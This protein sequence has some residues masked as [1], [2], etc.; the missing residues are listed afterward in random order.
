MRDEDGGGGARCRR[1]E[2]AVHVQR[3][4]EWLAADTSQRQR[5]RK[6]CVTW[7]G[8]LHVPIF[9][10]RRLAQTLESRQR[11][12]Q[13]D[14]SFSMSHSDVEEGAATAS[15]AAH[16]EKAFVAFGCR[17]G[18]QLSTVYLNK[19]LPRNRLA[20]PPLPAAAQETLTQHQRR[21]TSY[22]QLDNHAS[23]SLTHSTN[24]HRS[25]KA[26][27]NCRVSSNRLPRHSFAR[28]HPP[29]SSFSRLSACSPC[30]SLIIVH[31]SRCHTALRHILTSVFQLR[32]SRSSRSLSVPTCK[33]DCD[34][35]H[36]THP[37]RS[38]PLPAGK[39]CLDTGTAE[40][41][42]LWIAVQSGSGVT[43]SLGS[44]IPGFC[45]SDS[46]GSVPSHWSVAIPTIHWLST[47][48]I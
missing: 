21:L 2:I 4:I 47:P 44:V 23:P 37:I 20:P 38:S 18:H 29:I 41:R 22:A 5:Q 36:P 15:E 42:S 12:A 14:L 7:R 16:S 3:R 28:F 10:A 39:L 45:P 9:S 13:S 43:N 35:V 33:L 8:S 26:L 48:S 40:T 24:H 31:L 1:F 17:D 6:C 30:P 27:H 19:A 34:P 11:G 32:S 25:S 46:L